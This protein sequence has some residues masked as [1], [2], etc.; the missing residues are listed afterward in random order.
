MAAFIA[1]TVPPGYAIVAGKKQLRAVLRAAGNEVARNARAL[2]RSGGK[3]RVSLP[4][5][6]P[7][8]RSGNLARSI[9]LRPSRDG[10]RITIKDV[11][12][13]ALFVE[14]GAKG[15]V[16]SGRKGA[17]GKANRRG[18]T[19]GQRILAPHPF[20]QP[21]L[22]KAVGNGLTDRI[23]RAVVSG[24]AFQKVK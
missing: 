12:Y 24:L 5:Q 6:P 22:D 4:G 3:K 16:G 15:G 23:E 1:V 14:K 19:I 9:K 11:A 17:K 20:M 10:E 8:S 2:I 18:A 13:Y 7:V 21:A